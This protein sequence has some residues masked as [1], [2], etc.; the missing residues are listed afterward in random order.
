MDSQETLQAETQE[1]ASKRL[2]IAYR[3]VCGRDFEIN[4]KEGG[5]CPH[6]SRH[7]KPEAFVSPLNATISITGIDEP[8]NESAFDLHCYNELPRQTYGHFELDRKLGSGGMGAVYRA[9]DTSLQRF[10]AV[11]VMRYSDHNMDSRIASM[12]REAIA[13]ARL[14]HPNVVVI[15]YV[16]REREEPFLAM[17]L[18]PGP[19]L[20]EKLKSGE[21]ISYADAIRY[22]IQVASALEHASKFGIVHGDIKPGNLILTAENNIKLS[23]FGLSTI[24]SDSDKKV[25]VS[26]T[27]AYLAPEL[28]KEPGTM[29]SDM[30]ALGVTMFELVFGR[31]PF[32]LKGESVR[33]RLESHFDATIDFPQ[34][35][36]QG[37]PRAFSGVIEKLLAKNPSDR[38]SSFRELEKEL[39]LIQPVNTTTAAI[40][41]RVMAYVAD[42]AF[43]LLCLVPFVVPILFLMGDAFRGW[44]WII[45]ILAFFSLSVPAAYLTWVYRG[46]RSLGRY[47]FQLRIVE[48]NGLPPRSEQLVTREVLRNALSWLGPLAIYITL[49]YEWMLTIPEFLL[50]LFVAIDASVMF[51][52]NKRSALHDLLCHSRVVLAV[53]RSQNKSN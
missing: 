18:L 36:P 3:C 26:G 23:D 22:G 30:Y 27:P 50:V 24:A 33:E 15:Y 1:R 46:R 16:G 14:N 42:Q 2:C 32:E 6:C 31:Y 44:Q 48:E 38:Y 25:A 53:D 29:Q 9:L 13:Q 11:K 35:W 7:F 19:T 37:V 52:T 5:S 45:P 49:S 39:Q 12:L 34:I 20:A 28:L 17:E 8:E 10:V 43:L 47:L 41:P 40:A 51:I 4:P 21:K